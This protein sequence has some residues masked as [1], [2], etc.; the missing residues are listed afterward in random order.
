MRLLLF[1]AA[2]SSLALWKLADQAL[3]GG[4]DARDFFVSM[5]VLPLVFG[6]MWLRERALAPLHED[7][8]PRDSGSTWCVLAG[9]L[10]ASVLIAIELGVRERAETSS[11]LAAVLVHCWVS[12]HFT[13]VLIV[14]NAVRMSRGAMRKSTR[15]GATPAAAL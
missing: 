15:S 10:A 5:S 3:H 9:L 13:V 11:V 7:R 1:L 14:T 8:E 6:W 12:V 4:F 2:T